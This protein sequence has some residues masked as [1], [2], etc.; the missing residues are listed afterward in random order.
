MGVERIR[1]Y[2][3]GAFESLERLRPIKAR[4]NAMG[5]EVISTWLEEEALP[6]SGGKRAEEVISHEQCL[7]YAVRDLDEIHTANLLLVD[8][9]DQTVRG[10][11]EFEA[12][13]ARGLGLPVV[14]IGPRRNVFHHDV[15]HYET[16]D[17]YFA[18][19]S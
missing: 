19:R 18:G 6:H 15:E 7:A 12:G 17:E 14:V 1:T 13:Y 5:H 9:M 2:L 3:A 4:L 16:W 8:T 10:G 11:R